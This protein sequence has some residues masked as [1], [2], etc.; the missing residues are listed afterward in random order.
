MT[1]DE[2]RLALSRRLDEGLD[3]AEAKRLES[4]LA[5][6]ADCRGHAQ[7]LLTH[8]Q[9]LAEAAPSLP[10]GFHG[11]LLARLDANARGARS[12]RRA[13]WA[14]ALLAALAALIAIHQASRRTRPATAPAVEPIGEL[15]QPAAEPGPVRGPDRRVGPG[16]DGRP[17]PDLRLTEAESVIRRLPPPIGPGK[18][19]FRFRGIPETDPG[20]KPAD[21]AGEF[22]GAGLGAF[23]ADEE[24][25]GVYTRRWNRLERLR[26]L[27]AAGAVGEGRDGRLARPPRAALLNAED[28]ELVALENA[29]RA[30]LAALFARMLPEVTG[31][32]PK[33][34]KE[35]ARILLADVLRKFVETGEPVQRDDGSWER[36]TRRP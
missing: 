17:A 35:N 18:H 29:D 20:A 9:A 21:L 36:P 19:D 7:R 14:L 33:D 4:H 2:A 24:I 27:K 32:K 15:E 12:L 28:A 22:R 26:A 6:C 3:A 1:H 16:P 11:A 30:A 8:S 31:G 34:P 23:A 13:A 10:A 5:G 25:L